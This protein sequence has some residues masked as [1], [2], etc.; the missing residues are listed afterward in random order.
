MGHVVA[1]VLA[2]RENSKSIKGAASK[3]AGPGGDF[4]AVA[5]RGLLDPVLDDADAGLLVVLR[6]QISSASEKTSIDDL[7]WKRQAGGVIRAMSRL[8]A[9]MR[10]MRANSR[11]LEREPAGA[12]RPADPRSAWDAR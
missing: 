11:R 9:T 1:R 6:S 8:S 7:L 5:P 10:S 3:R 12:P 2:N 4:D